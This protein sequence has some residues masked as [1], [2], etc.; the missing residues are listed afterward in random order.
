MSKFGMYFHFFG[1][2]LEIVRL[3]FFR[4]LIIAI[5]VVELIA[6]RYISYLT[7]MVESKPLFI[8]F[9]A[10]LKPKFYC[11]THCFKLIALVILHAEFVSIFLTQQYVYLHLK[12]IP[13]VFFLLLL[14]HTRFRI[15]LTNN[16]RL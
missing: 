7:L 15:H 8:G 6:R 2:R 16:H 14:F 1:Y 11:G 3:P 13:H 5:E 4:I 9:G 10:P 12:Q